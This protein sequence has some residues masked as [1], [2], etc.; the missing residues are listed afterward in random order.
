VLHLTREANLKKLL[1]LL[2][3]F[4]P[5]AASAQQNAFSPQTLSELKQIQKAALANDYAYRHLEHLCDNI[6]PRPAGSPQFRFA[7]N[8]VA[9]E[10]RKLGLD[11]KL[12]KSTVTP[13]VRGEETGQVVQ[14]AGM[15]PG[16]TQKLVLTALG[17]S[18]ATPPE[19]IT[20]DAVVVRDF[21]E[22]AALGRDKVAGKIVVF[23]AQFDRAMAEGGL[24]ERAYGEAVEYRSRGA[25]EAAKLGAVA[26]L[27]RSVGTAEFRIPHTGAVN[28]FIGPIVPAAALTAED[29]DLLARLAEQGPVRLHITL[30]PKTLPP[31]DE[32]N[33]VAD[34]KGSEHPEQ[35]VLVSG[36]LDSW[37][38]GTGAIDDGAGV[39]VSMEVANVLQQLK[40][41]PKRTIRIVAWSNEEHGLDGGISY[42]SAH[43]AEAANHI[44]AIETDLGAG[45]P[46]G[47]DADADASALELLAPVGKILQSQGAGILRASENPGADLIPLT[48]LGVPAF[49]PIQDARTYFQYHHTPA[50]TF[51]KVDR[52]QLQE[53]AAVVAV[54]AYALAS[55]D[56]TIQHKP[57]PLPAWLKS[58]MQQK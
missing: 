33:V 56:A 49:A 48:V 14:W 55:T 39:A 7:G 51:D 3:L 5:L 47:I 1:A 4:A 35:V 18:P 42:A 23:D 54:L 32:F 11:V 13:W 45:H 24:A 53:N 2:T 9:D 40:L 50:D 52:Q 25:R 43:Q 15:A 8:Y 20:A 31:V 58:R 17:G 34:I 29:A 6:G 28:T 22:L 27:I 36:H 57:Q 46:Y 37:D 12:E 41:R 38:L 30:T 44:G 16:S 10:L 26:S 21:D 19:G